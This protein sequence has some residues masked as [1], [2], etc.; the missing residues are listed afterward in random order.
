MFALPGFLATALGRRI[1]AGL[2]VALLLGFVALRIYVAGGNAREQKVRAEETEK[3]EQLRQ[4]DRAELES[5]LA[6]A[7][8]RE[9]AAR[10]RE[11]EAVKRFEDALRLVDRATER[12]ANIQT[13]RTAEHARVDALPDNLLTP[14][15]WRA[16]GIRRADDPTSGFYPDELRYLARCTTDWPLCQQQAEALQ[17]KV[18]GLDG[19]VKALSDQ[20]R[21]VTDRAE[22]TA[23]KVEAFTDYTINLERYYVDAYNALPRRARSPKCLWIWKCRDKSL[24]VPSPA[25]VEALRP[26]APPPAGQAGEG[27]DP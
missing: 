26:Q 15:I 13:E 11:A 12:L 5:K 14:H 6:E 9:A 23:A 1:L 17:E 27:R 16:I 2:G 4:Q 22:A 8:E 10:T 21:A 19:E 25:E 24:P 3:A 20:V 18:A 7:A